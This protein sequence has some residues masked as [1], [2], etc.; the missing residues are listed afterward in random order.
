MSPEYPIAKKPK[1]DQDNDLSNNE[2]VLD[3]NT[4]SNEIKERNRFLA[5]R[6]TL[7]LRPASGFYPNKNLYFFKKV[8]NKLKN[9]ENGLNT[10]KEKDESSNNNNNTNDIN[11]DNSNSNNNNNSNN[12]SDSD[13]ISSDVG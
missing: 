13:S 7:G 4:E 11:K 3:I 9:K 12:D 1:L 8:L 10:I 2:I 6:G 5:P